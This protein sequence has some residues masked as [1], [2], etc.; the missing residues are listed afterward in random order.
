MENPKLSLCCL[1]TTD[2]V[3]EIGYVPY[4]IQYMKNSDILWD[5]IVLGGIILSYDCPTSLAYGTEWDCHY[6]DNRF[7]GISLS[8]VLFKTI[9]WIGLIIVHERQNNI[10]DPYCL[11]R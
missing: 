7:L 9:E 10:S 1:R 11:P 8:L 6:W 4:L 2:F 5:Y 3:R